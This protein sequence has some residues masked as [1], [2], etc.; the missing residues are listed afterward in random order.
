MPYSSEREIVLA[1]MGSVPT[2]PHEAAAQARI[3]KALHEV[4][5]AASG[6]LDPA[7]L[8]SLTIDHARSLLEGDTATLYWWEESEGRLVRIA[9]NKRVVPRPSASPVYSG[10]SKEMWTWLWAAR[11]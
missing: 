6:V 11:L 1:L 9:S 8:A 5:L 3:F 2:R 10:C 7:E 4:A